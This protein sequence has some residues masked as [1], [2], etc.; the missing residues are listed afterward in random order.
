MTILNDAAAYF[1]ALREALLLATRQVYIIGWDIHSQT[2]FVGP[3]GYADD[4][5]PQELGAFLKALL[6]AK[7]D[8]RINILIWN[9]PALYA[10]ER[11]WNSAA[12][13]TA[14]ASDRLRFCFDSSLPLGSAQHQKIVVIDGALGFVGG[15]DLTIRRWDTSAHETHHPLRTDPDGKPYP[16]FHDV[17]CM[18]DGEAAASLT[19]VA[20]NRWRAAGCTMERPAATKGERWPASVPVQCR[21]MT[22]GIAR[23]EI[24]TARGDGVSEVARLFE[25][26]INAADRFIYIENQFTSATDIARLLAQRMLDVP[27]LRV[28]IV[29][30]K[31][32]SSWFESQAMQSGRGGF[33]AR[34]V[35]AGVMDRVRFV[36]PSTR[37]AEQTAAVMVHSK[38]MIVDDRILRVGSANL[39]N[40][41]M[42]ADTECDLAFEAT[43]D[44]HC[45]Y[46]AW[47]RRSLIGHFCDVDEREI[48]RH[49]ADL[50]GFLDRLAEDDVPKS[51]QPIDPAASVGGVAV[52]VQPVAD[53]REPLH[54]DR[55]ANRMWTARTILAVFGLAAA[56][57]GLALAWQYTS[58]RD[59]ADVGF[60]SSIISQPARSQFAPLFAIAAFVVGGLVVFPVLV[61]IAATSAA[62]GPWMGFLSASAGVLLSALTLF[63][64]GRVLGQARLQR[65]LGR[66]AA[67]VQSG[68]IGK[69][70]MAVA[71][72]RM[73]PIAPFSI[74]NLVAGASKLSLR[75]FVLGTVLGMAPGIAVMAALGAQIADL[76]RNASWINVLLL[77]LAILA[78]IALCLGVQFLVTW[79]AGR[80]T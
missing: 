66:R 10:A 73:V 9:F 72:I 41:S 6:K 26:S 29:M 17:Q 34:F 22:A 62:L 20:E 55:A 30:P 21:G 39:N 80:R 14:H 33:I 70:V 49:E 27:Q 5:Y 65:L 58:L 56:L 36:Y 4:G 76:A 50:F 32:H 64:I 16:P 44:T 18:V 2:R 28:L 54:L 78:W 52:M 38:V 19:E 69:G 75:D 12:K 61:L 46:I 71:M 35:S 45:E 63:S 77:A 25:A 51:L 57:A 15:L 40:R 68:I 42:G 31:M 74:V 8:L 48:E 37:D 3:S 23:T 47:L 67:R 53:P 13:F 79:L 7:R 24:A 60:V 43:S 1:A 11:E 59:F